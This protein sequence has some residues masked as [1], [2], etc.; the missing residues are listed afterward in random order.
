MFFKPEEFENTSF[1]F[2]RTENIIFENE[3]LRKRWK[4]RVVNSLKTMRRVQRSN[5][6]TRKWRAVNSLK[7]MRLWYSP[8]RVFLNHK[9]KITVN[10]C[11]FKFL[12]R[13]AEGK[14][15]M[16]SEWNLRFQIPPAYCERG[17]IKIR[18]PSTVVSYSRVWEMHCNENI[19]NSKRE[20]FSIWRARVKYYIFNFLPSISS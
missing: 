15:L 6:N 1:L 17:L 14:Y 11:V 3:A 12:P 8:A 9:F 18:Y 16:R 19:G 5:E 7:T 20:C 13:S 10:C 2:L 4:W